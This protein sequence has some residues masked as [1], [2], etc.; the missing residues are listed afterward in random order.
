MRVTLAVTVTAM[1]RQWQ[2]QRRQ[3][4]RQRRP[5]GLRQRQEG[6]A[7]AYTV[8][9]MAAGRGAAAACGGSVDGGER[10]NSSARRRQRHRGDEVAACAM[11]TAS[12]GAKV[13]RQWRPRHQW[14]VGSISS[15]TTAAANLAADRSGDHPVPVVPFLPP[16][17]EWRRM[18]PRLRPPKGLSNL[19]AQLAVPRAAKL[20]RK[21]RIKQTKKPERRVIS[22][23]CT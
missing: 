23:F 20:R 15:G 9:A 21:C 13:R 3:E 5:E 10:G 22:A 4:G 17:G 18:F 7:A 8:A 6:A 12:C 14:G 19:G 2:Q 16:L 1:G 11:A